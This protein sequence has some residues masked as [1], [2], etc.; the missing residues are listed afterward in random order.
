MKQENTRVPE[1]YE[2]SASIWDNLL[3]FW[4]QKPPRW[5]VASNFYH[6]I[7]REY[8]KELL[9]ILDMGGDAYT[10]IKNLRQVLEENS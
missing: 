4:N 7:R 3:R 1:I 5:A 6:G 10:K 2:Q 8:S 9:K